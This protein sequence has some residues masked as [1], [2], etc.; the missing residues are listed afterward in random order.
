MRHKEQ[1]GG[2]FFEKNE[3]SYE[4][5]NLYFLCVFA[6]FNQRQVSKPDLTSLM[7]VFN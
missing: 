6:D 4:N 5:R 1:K 3:M 2:M 7:C